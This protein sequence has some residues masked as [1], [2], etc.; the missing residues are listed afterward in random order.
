MMIRDGE[1]VGG[2]ARGLLQSHQK[3]AGDDLRASEVAAGVTSEMNS[4][5]AD[6]IGAVQDGRGCRKPNMVAV[7]SPGLS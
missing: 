2:W 5:A 1:I 3:V 6:F 4:L 7:G